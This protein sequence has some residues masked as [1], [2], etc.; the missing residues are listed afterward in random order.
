MSSGEGA[1]LFLR[2][3]LTFFV[4][5][6]DFERSARTESTQAAW[7]TTA[8]E[9]AIRR[10]FR[11]LSVRARRATILASASLASL[12][13]LMREQPPRVSVARRASAKALRATGLS[14][15]IGRLHEGANLKLG[16]E[17]RVGAV[18]EYLGGAAGGGGHSD[19]IGH[20]DALEAGNIGQELSDLI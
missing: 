1:G 3:P 11:R 13:P 17:Q 7:R 14:F 16:F 12:S 20:D 18:A 8:T 15:R 19:I 10:A 2:F 5:T 4:A 6:G 9:S